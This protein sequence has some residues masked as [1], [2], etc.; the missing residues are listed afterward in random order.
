MQVRRSWIFAVESHEQKVGLTH[1]RLETPGAEASTGSRAASEGPAED[2]CPEPGVEGG[3]GHRITTVLMPQTIA[4]CYGAL[5]GN[6][7]NIY[8]T[9]VGLQKL[10]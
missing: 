9:V 3:G 1:P 10:I 2:T 4:I 6:C 7:C 8:F 5:L